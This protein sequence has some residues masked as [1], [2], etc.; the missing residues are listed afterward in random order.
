[1]LYLDIDTT[2]N[3]AVLFLNNYNKDYKDMP[4]ALEIY[5]HKPAR[6][7]D[8]TWATNK[9]IEANLVSTS[10][11]YSNN[12]NNQHN[13]NNNKNKISN[14]SIKIQSQLTQLNSFYRNINTGDRYTLL[15]V[16]QIGIQL[17]LNNNMLLGTIDFTHNMTITEQYDLARILYSMVWTHSTIFNYYA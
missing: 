14:L 3:S 12:N 6:A 1:V 17:Y 16:P 15:Y 2:D 4:I 8:L 9:F 11:D 13:K 5:Y 7:V 10:N